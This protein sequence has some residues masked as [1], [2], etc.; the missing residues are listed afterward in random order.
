MRPGCGC[1][2]F[3][4]HSG[5]AGRPQRPE[6]VV[7]AVTEG[8]CSWLLGLD[9]FSWAVCAGK[10]NAYVCVFVCVCSVCECE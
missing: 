8:A 3:L 10:K 2:G 5:K 7:V 9:S 4:D 1:P 6:R